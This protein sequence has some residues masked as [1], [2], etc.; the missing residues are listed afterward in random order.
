LWLDQGLALPR[1][2]VNLSGRQVTSG[3]LIQSVQRAL[4]EATL[5]P[6][7]LVLELTEST[8]M[9]P[10]EGVQACLEELR[11]LG[12][13]LSIDDFGTGYSSLAYLKHFPLD[14]LKID[15]SF[16]CDVANDRDDAAIVGAVIGMAH[17]LELGV[18]AEGVETEAQLAFLRELGC[19]TAQGH[20]FAEALPPDAFEKLLREQT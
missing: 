10:T 7:H 19:E 15:R 20:L 12:V 17:S 4:L 1:V 8:L 5:F 11:A 9:D 2:S 18:V 14:H 13:R 6:H 3:T 16:V